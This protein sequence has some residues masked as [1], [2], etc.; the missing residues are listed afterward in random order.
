MTM[1]GDPAVLAALASA[2]TYPGASTP[3]VAARLGDRG[4]WAS[5]G[6]AADLGAYAAALEGRTVEA[7][8]EQFIGAFDFDPKC[9]LD[10]GWHLYGE[11]YDRGD[12]LVRMRELLGR[13]GIDEGTELPDHLPHVLRLLARMPDEEAATLAAQSVVPAVDKILEGLGGREGPYPALMR[14]V[15]TVVSAIAHPTLHEAPHV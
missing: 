15:R 3:E 12:F 10:I 5:T 4:R 2:L 6:A 13:H 14:G 7:M 1:A 8:Q 11:N 9:S